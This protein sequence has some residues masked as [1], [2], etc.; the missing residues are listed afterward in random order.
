MTIEIIK[1]VTG[2]AWSTSGSVTSGNLGLTISGG[3]GYATGSN[4]GTYYPWDSGNERDTAPHWATSASFVELSGTGAA[5]EFCS[6]SQV[7]TLQRETG[8]ELVFGIQFKLQ[9]AF[10]AGTTPPNN[11]LSQLGVLYDNGTSNY[12]WRIDFSTRNVAGFR[13]GIYFGFAGQSS[14][15]A[16]VADVQ[17]GGGSARPM[18]HAQL[19]TWYPGRIRYK[20]G[21][22]SGN[23]SVLQFWLGDVMIMQ[24]TNIDGDL[25]SASYYGA[26]LAFLR[27]LD[28]ITGLRVRFC[29]PIRVQVVPD[30]DVYHTQDS[31]PWT[32]NTTQGRA[33]RRRWSA[34]FTGA[35]SPITVSGTATVPAIGT[36]YSSGGTFPGRSYLPVS[37]T[38]GQT[39][40]LTFPALWGGNAAD[41]PFGEDG[42]TTI[43]FDD[44]MP[45]TSSSLIARIYAAD[46]T[47]VLCK[48]ELVASGGT[49]TF[50]VNDVTKKTGLA[51]EESYQVLIQIGLGE[52]TV[53]LKNMSEDTKNA[54]LMESWSVA[55]D[56]DDGDPLGTPTVVGSFTGTDTV[57]VAGLCAVADLW[58]MIGDSYLGADAGSTPPYQCL[59]Q[60]MGLYWNTA[61][62]ATLPGGYDTSLQAEDSELTGLEFVLWTSLS[63]SKLS[64]ELQYV[65]PQNTAIRFA[66]IVCFGF[67]VNDIPAASSIGSRTL[68]EQAAY[69]IAER[70]VDLAEWVRDN[71][72]KLWI[73]DGFNLRNTGSDPMVHLFSDS[74]NANNTY[75]RPIPGMVASLVPTM[76]RKVP[77]IDGIVTH[78]PTASRIEASVTTIGSDSVHPDATFD[79]L[80]VRF[81]REGQGANSVWS[82]YADTVLND[83]G[84][85]AESIGG[86]IGFGSGG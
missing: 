75:R 77:G 14:A 25:G 5:F 22:A 61:W 29:G 43:S 51:D 76:L 80:S 42:I 60:R 78:I 47:T 27:E 44:L 40:T 17:G 86:R 82:A 1:E 65:M 71:G 52:A 68:A 9:S 58:W 21:T 70:K 12:P 26:F 4:T 48:C 62:D 32:I 59:G 74:V 3:D 20:Q 24:S 57:R 55:C 23:N 83:D 13:P 56:Y 30:A 45:G 85:L 19:D 7:S 33:L 72:H 81:F 6:L 10:V 67:D 28:S 54:N 16:T 50:K 63:G 18:S 2:A 11:T 38:V 36:R 73:G 34:R 15:T 37:G 46:N 39:F 49:V 41:T 8:V 35:G 66:R 84:S 64:E 53:I 69:G 31:R 79:P